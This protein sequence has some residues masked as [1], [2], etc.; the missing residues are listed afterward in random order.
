MAVAKEGDKVKVQFVGTLEDGTIL[1]R[2]DEDEL[3]EF[4]IGAGRLLPQFEIAVIG[5]SEGDTKTISL[6][7]EDAY[8][9]RREELVFT[10]ERSQVPPH[11]TPEVGKRVRVR[12]GSGDMAI[13]TVKNIEGDK[14]T[15][16]GNDPLAGKK[17][18]FEIKLLE[19]TQGEEE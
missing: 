1:G 9:P 2:T 6:D 17:L 8:G 12:L 11:I 16:D 5:M 14:V 10:V 19:I 13:A 7:P 4:T 15:F 3:F 18:T